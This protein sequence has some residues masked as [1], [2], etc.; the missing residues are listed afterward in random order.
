MRLLFATVTALLSI[1]AARSQTTADSVAHA[2]EQRLQNA[3]VTEWQIRHYVVGRV[4]K[5]VL[6]ASAAQWTATAKALRTKTLD[7]A[8]QGWPAE[9]IQS[10]P[11]F[12]DLGYIPAGKGYRLR[13]L[14]YTVVP[15]FQS[16]ALLYEPETLRGKIPAI[17]NVNGHEPEGKAMEYIQKRCISQARQGILALNLE[18]IGMGELADPENVHW[19]EAYLDLA[20][21]NALGLF[22]LEMRRGLDYLWQHPNVDR[23]RVGITGLSGGGWQSIVLGALDERVLVAV[24][25]AGYLSSMSLGGAEWVGDNEQSATDFGTPADAMHLTAMRAPRPT[26]LI[27]NANDNCCFRAPRMKPF[28]YDAVRPFF[29]LYGAAEKFS[30]YENTDPGDHNYQLDNRLRSY[31]FFARYFGLTPPARETPADADIQTREQLDVGLPANNLTL[32]TL[33]RT[34]ASR[35][36]R[37]AVQPGGEARERDTL[38][39]LV[40]YHAAHVNFAWPVADSWGGGMRTIGYRFDFDNELSA[41]G[42]WFKAVHAPVD[43]A[44]TVVLD[45]RGKKASSAAVSGLVNRA[46]QALAVDLLFTGDAAPPKYYYPVYDRMLATLGERSLGIEAAQLIGIVDWL[47][48]TSGQPTGRVMV[49]GKR[50]QAVVLVAAAIEPSLFSQVTVREGL[51][52]WSKVFDLP[53]RYLDAPELFCLELY[54]YFDVDRLTA[55]AKPVRFDTVARN[56]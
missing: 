29:E 46:E 14:R 43:T 19:N 38:K 10:A 12:E 54:R 41:S 13:K 1:A 6:P 21:V 52:S 35:I 53:I 34:F 30:W 23:A 28:L 31:D 25:N 18:W 36:Q 20:G 8:F 5:L 47:R 32:L 26:L 22:Y 55:L 17:L 11:V 27:Y 56:Q 42:T 48:K 39:Q 2:M 33:A 15:G 37:S 44:W 3:D 49:S 4:P 16:T 45:D 40:R 7:V 24:P 50:N 9:W 51:E